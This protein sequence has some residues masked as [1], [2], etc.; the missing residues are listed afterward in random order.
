MYDGG[1]PSAMTLH[2]QHDAK[3]M[4]SYAV[5]LCYRSSR[6]RCLGMHRRTE[7]ECRGLAQSTG[8]I[9]RCNM[10]KKLLMVLELNT[11][12]CHSTSSFRDTTNL[13][14]DDQRLLPRW[15]EQR[16]LSSRYSH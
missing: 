13:H 4:E 1:R 16:R 14:N 8:N 12:S 6:T 9:M 10:N 2:I 11:I 7:V 3:I 5:A 15:S